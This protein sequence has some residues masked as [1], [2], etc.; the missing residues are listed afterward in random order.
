[1]KLRPEQEAILRRH[2]RATFEAEALAHVR[3]HFAE[4]VSAQSNEQLLQRIRS[5]EQRA[6]GYGLDT[7]RQVICFL[8]TSLLLGEYFDTNPAYGWALK[9][10]TSKALSP[11]DRAGLLLAT[12]CSVANRASRA[13]RI[14]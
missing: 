7:P 13:P 2:S 4:S 12:A 1:M 9:T 3:Q 10:L 5:C 6:A 11:S 14:I 8:D